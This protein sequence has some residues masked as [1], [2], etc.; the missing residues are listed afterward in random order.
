MPELTSVTMTRARGSTGNESLNTRRLAITVFI[1]SVLILSLSS[2]DSSN[3]VRGTSLEFMKGVGFPAFTPNGY[4]SADASGQLQLVPGLGADWVAIIVTLYQDTGTSTTQYNDPTRTPSDIS[5]T[6]I[7]GLA[8]SLGLKVLLKPHLGVLDGTNHQDIHPSD[9]NAWFQSWDQNML[10]YAQL[11]AQNNVEMF[12]IGGE[13]DTMDG[14]AANWR[15]IVSDVRGVYSGPLVYGSSQKMQHFM[16]ITWW[17]AVDYAGIDAYFPLATQTSNPT[18]DDLNAS[19]ANWIT[20]LNGWQRTIGKPVI[21]TEIG[22]NSVVGANV[23]PAITIQQ[24]NAQGIP[25]DLNLQALLYTSMFQK[26]YVIPWFRGMFI[27]FW[28]TKTNLQGPNDRGFSPQGKPAQDALTQWYHQDWNSPMGNGGGVTSITSINS[29]TNTQ[30][31]ASTTT[32]SKQSRVSQTTS[33]SSSRTTSSSLV[34]SSTYSSASTTSTVTTSSLTTVVSTSVPTMTVVNTPTTTSSSTTI[35]VST[36][37]VQPAIPGFPWESIIAG[38]M[39][40]MTALAIV[41]RR[42][43]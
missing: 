11:A 7:I 4:E 13:L 6:T 10:H 14:Y 19:W 29:T 28:P 36:P 26:L 8:H 22:Y 12:W 2:L 3:R 31:S 16:T 21:F 20:L 1:L 35:S 5:L 41:R 27:W 23:N 30:S 9:V 17:D 25:I 24:I 40:G 42:K 18:L 15:Q 32:S 37:M 43:K 33:T 34:S 39:L 38:I